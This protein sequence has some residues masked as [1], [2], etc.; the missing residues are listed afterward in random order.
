MP[1]A[2]IILMAFLGSFDPYLLKRLFDDT[3]LDHEEPQFIDLIS[4]ENE[5]PKSKGWTI[6]LSK[7]ATSGSKLLVSLSI[8]ILQ[9]RL[10]VF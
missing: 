8:A 3:K 1:T 6:V 4:D 10:S 2:Y 7:D 5:E 9:F